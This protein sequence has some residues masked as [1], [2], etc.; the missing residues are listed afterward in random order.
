LIFYITKSSKSLPDIAL[1]TFS[2]WATFLS[3][4][5]VKKKKE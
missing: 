1:S 5:L 2:T 4:S 3:A